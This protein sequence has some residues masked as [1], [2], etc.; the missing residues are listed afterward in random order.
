MSGVGHFDT[1]KLVI[2]MLEIVFVRGCNGSSVYRQAMRWLLDA[3]QKVLNSGLTL[4]IYISSHHFLLCSSPSTA[5]YLQ[6]N[7][8]HNP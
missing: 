4:Y 8:Y 3:V 6:E 1:V 7:T 2:L 5:A